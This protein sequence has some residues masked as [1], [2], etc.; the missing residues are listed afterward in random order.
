MAQMWPNLSSVPM[1]SGI[2]GQIFFSVIKKNWWH[3]WH[4]YV[5]ELLSLVLLTN[6]ILWEDITA[7]GGHATPFEFMGFMPSRM[8]TRA[9]VFEKDKKHVRTFASYEENEE[10]F[11]DRNVFPKSCIIS[12]KKISEK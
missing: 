8:I 9:Y 5:F 7:D 4:T 11:S 12:M 3:R 10:L 2:L 6:E 1:H